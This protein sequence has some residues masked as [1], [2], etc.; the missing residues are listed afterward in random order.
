LFFADGTML[1]WDLADAEHRYVPTESLN[2]GCGLSAE[3]QG[4]QSSPS[5]VSALRKNGALQECYKAVN[6]TVCLRDHAPSTA[7]PVLTCLP[8]VPVCHAAFHHKEDTLSFFNV[9]ERIPRYGNDVRLLPG[10]ERANFVG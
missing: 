4:E 6:R 9:V 1:S 3:F 10:F 8:A 2:S 7:L 5:P